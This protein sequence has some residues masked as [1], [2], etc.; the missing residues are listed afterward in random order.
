MGDH[1]MRLGHISAFTTA[2][3]IG[4]AVALGASGGNALANSEGHGHSKAHRHHHYS[5]PIVVKS[6]GAR[7]FA[8]TELRNPED[9]TAYLACDHGYVEWD[10]PFKARKHPLVLTHGSGTRVYQTTM[11]GQPGFQSIFLRKRF[12]VYLVDYPRTGRAGQGCAEYTYTP[13]LNSS[14]NTFQNR[15]GIWPPGDPEPQYFPGVAFSRDPEALDQALRVQYP[16]FNSPENEE[17]ESDALAVLLEELYKERGAKS[18]V[19]SHSS[20]ATR[21]WL[22]ATKTDK[23]AGLISFE[24]ANMMF[25]EGEEPPP[26]LRADGQMVPYTGRIVPLEEFRKL[27]KFPI[28]IVWGDNIPWELDPI[29]TGSRLGL[30]NRRISR[31]RFIRFVAAINRHGGNARN[32]FLPE[33][34]VTGNTHRPMADT[35]VNAVANQLWR[36]MKRNG[37]DKPGRKHHDKQYR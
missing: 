9:P 2:A 13:N 1:I 10:I 18:V 34:G 37:L 22:G 4:L 27:T 12:A 21:G 31:E 29:N 32:L 20:G 28:L 7:A 30:D 14:R 15:I 25:P 19:M 33:V 35:N 36:W 26:A 24:P 6:M 11:D 17:L 16:E 5:A 3:A 8:G 23:F